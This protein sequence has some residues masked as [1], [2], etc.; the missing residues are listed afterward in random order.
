VVC[1]LQ[2][3]AASLPMVFVVKKDLEDNLHINMIEQVGFFEARNLP[4]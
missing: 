3:C 1:N 2:L 4:G